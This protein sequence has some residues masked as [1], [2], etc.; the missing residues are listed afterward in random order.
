M[1]HHLHVTPDHAVWCVPD[2]QHGLSCLLPSTGSTPFD[3]VEVPGIGPSGVVADCREAPVEGAEA[4]GLRALFD[5]TSPALYAAA[6][7]AVPL[8][9]WQRTARHCGVCGS[10]MARDPAERAMVC[11]ACGFRA[12]PRI[13]P[14]VIVRVTRGNEVLLA[15]R[16]ATPTGFFSVIAGFV[17]AGESLE[18]ALAR[19]VREEAGIEIRDIRYFR[20]QPWSF[21]NNL[22]VGFTAEHANGE[23]RPDGVEMAEAGW[24]RRDALP[25]LPGP[26][27]IARKM[28]DA[29]LAERP[30]RPRE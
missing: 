14:V 10:R 26:V 17:E 12:Y 27:S 25:A 20:S 2:A 19:E 16:A 6:A 8:A 24:F 7:R 11:P 4:V 15:R 29:W 3:S 18:E 23:V 28:I 22:M 21:P 30:R 1:I 5:R 9:E 13:N